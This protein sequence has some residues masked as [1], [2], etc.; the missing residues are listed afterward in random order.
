[1]L[2][3]DTDYKNKV[4]SWNADI[5]LISTF[6]FVTEEEFKVFA[7][8]DQSYLIK[9]VKEDT[10]QQITGTSRYRLDPTV[11]LLTGCG[12]SDETMPM[13]VTNGPITV[14]G[15]IPIVSLMI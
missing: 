5:H 7:K 12:F 2:L 13:N 6:G 1:M 15:N 9:T 10:V 14:I 4:S 11:C 3:L 8:E